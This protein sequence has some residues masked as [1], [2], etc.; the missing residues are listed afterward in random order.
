MN[1]MWFVGFLTGMGRFFINYHI[2]FVFVAGIGRL[3]AL[4]RANLSDKKLATAFPP[5]AIHLVLTWAIEHGRE[6]D[7]DLVISLGINHQRKAGIEE[8]NRKAAK[9]FNETETNQKKRKANEKDSWDLYMTW[10][11]KYWLGKRF[12]HLLSRVGFAN[13]RIL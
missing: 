6:L 8:R 9:S 7:V 10:T 4:H 3:L 1:V 11:F 2:R 12:I 13:R 5:K